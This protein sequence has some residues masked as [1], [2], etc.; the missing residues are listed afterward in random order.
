MV[1]VER[2]SYSTLR[3]LESLFELTSL[4]LFSCSGDVI[5]SNLGLSSKLTEYAL[6]VG[7][8]GRRCL[9]TSLMDNYYDRIMDLK[10]TESTPLADWI[11]HMLRKSELVHSNGNGSNNVLTELLV[12]K[13]QNVKDLRLAV[14]DSLTHLLSIHCQNDIPFSKLKRLEITRFCSLQYLFTC[15]WL[16]E[17]RQTRQ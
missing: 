4:T 15:P 8:Q 10:V 16:Q 12:D 5:Y 9:D 17:V 3:E 11:C 14:C 7:Q 6:K 13:F 1:G 2:C